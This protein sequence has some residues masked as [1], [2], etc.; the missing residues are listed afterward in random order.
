MKETK[1]INK[2]VRA[3]L[4]TLLKRDDI[5][6]EKDKHVGSIIFYVKDNDGKKLFSYE[7]SHELNRHTIVAPG[8]TRKDA[9]VVLAQVYGDENNAAPQHQDVLDIL[10]ALNTKYTKLQEMDHARKS[11]SSEEAMFISSLGKAK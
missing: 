9:P 10:E 5:V 4:L 6:I 1:S 7:Q 2:Y 8:K 3:T 11:L